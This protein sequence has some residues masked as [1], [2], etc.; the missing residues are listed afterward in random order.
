M[1]RIL[2]RGMGRKQVIEDARAIEGILNYMTKM[3]HVTIRDLVMTQNLEPKP[4]S[5]LLKI[6]ANADVV[7]KIGKR[8]WAI[9]ITAAMNGWDAGSI[10]EKAA[11][12]AADKNME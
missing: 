2:K 9:T 1:N 7:E 4:V 11:N 12:G 8:Q 5:R 3:S 6:L 10:A